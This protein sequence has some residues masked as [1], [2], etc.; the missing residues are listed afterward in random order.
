MNVHVYIVGQCACVVDVIVTTSGCPVVYGGCSVFI[1]C[2]Q[3]CC[4]HGQLPLSR[5]LQPMAGLCPLIHSWDTHGKTTWSQTFGIV[6]HQCWPVLFTFW[7]WCVKK[8]PRRPHSSSAFAADESRCYIMR[9]ALMPGTSD[10]S[11]GPSPSLSLTH[12]IRHTPNMV[13]H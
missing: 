13:R 8:K 3:C 4:P 2:N 12:W 10:G 6:H 7:I 5:W 9:L 1:G 11:R